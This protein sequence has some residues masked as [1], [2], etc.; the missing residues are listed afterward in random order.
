MVITSPYLYQEIMMNMAHISLLLE[1]ECQLDSHE[2]NCPFS[3]TST[4][5]S[6]PLFPNICHLELTIKTH[7]EYTSYLSPKKE[8]KLQGCSI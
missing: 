3:C 6:K 5:L 2:I 1:T 4:F 8:S 7:Q